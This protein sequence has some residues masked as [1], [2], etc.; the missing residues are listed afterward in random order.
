MVYRSVRRGW[1]RDGCGGDADGG[2]DMTPSTLSTIIGA[3]MLLISVVLIALLVY[4]FLG[5]PKNCN[6]LDLWAFCGAIGMCV[7]GAVV[8]YLE[9]FK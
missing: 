3:A 5:K 4:I 9:V 1:V 8:S 2:V 6:R 7:A